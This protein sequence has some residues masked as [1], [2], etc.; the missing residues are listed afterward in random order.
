MFIPKS[1]YIAEGQR[2]DDRLRQEGAQTVYVVSD[3]QVIQPPA[4]I[5]GQAECE[6][7]IS[8]QYILKRQHCPLKF[9]R[10]LG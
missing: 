3:G 2:L 10:G 9:K 6:T 5:V 8:L 4:T 7:S 1:E